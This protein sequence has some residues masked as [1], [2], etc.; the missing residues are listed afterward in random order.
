MVEVLHSKV[1]ALD[2]IPQVDVLISEPMGSM[3]L[4]ERM[5]ESYIA[6]RDSVCALLCTAAE[7][8]WSAALEA[9]RQDAS[10]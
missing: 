2:Q 7:L 5:L 8:L 1:E 10:W 6:A 3:L 9:R 4:S